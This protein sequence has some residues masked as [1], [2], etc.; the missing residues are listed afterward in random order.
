MQFLNG[1]PTLVSLRSEIPALYDQ[2]GRKMIAPKQR[3][4]F[5]KFE[6]GIPAWAIPIAEST[7]DFATMPPE[8]SVAQWCGFY[9]SEADQIQRGWTNDERSV[10]EL[11]LV[12]RNYLAVEKP[13]SEIPYPSYLK[14]RK[15]HGKRTVEHV[16]TDIRATLDM[17]GESAGK[18]IAYESDHTDEHSQAIIDA[19]SAS[20]APVTESEEDLVAA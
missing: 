20:A 11:A 15:I 5:A 1:D 4:L 9:D 19:L 17:T 6:R 7:F 18:V 8:R 14:Q 10:I 13:R 16:L 12:E 3:R 2:G